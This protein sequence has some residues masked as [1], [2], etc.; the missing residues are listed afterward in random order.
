MEQVNRRTKCDCCG[1]RENSKKIERMIDEA[2]KG[3][4]PLAKAFEKA[5]KTVEERSNDHEKRRSHEYNLRVMNVE[6]GDRS[7]STLV[8]AEV[9]APLMDE[10]VEYVKQEVETAHP[11][12]NPSVEKQ[13]L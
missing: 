4:K 2:E 1:G 13:T 8:V 12:A 5:N 10:T 7:D 3:R 6:M 9:L 11:L